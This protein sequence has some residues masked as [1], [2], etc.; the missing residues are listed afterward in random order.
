MSFPSPDAAKAADEAK[1]TQI[2]YLGLPAEVVMLG[3]QVK[4]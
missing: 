2:T 1:K 3:M 4:G